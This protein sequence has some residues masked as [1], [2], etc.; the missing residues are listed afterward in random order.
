MNKEIKC[1]E[2]REIEKVEERLHD[3]DGVKDEHTHME[4]VE[5]N[6]G[7]LAECFVTRCKQ[8]DSL[9][10][11]RGEGVCPLEADHDQV[12]LVELCEVERATAVDGYTQS[13]GGYGNPGSAC[14]GAKPQRECPGVCV[15]ECGKMRAETRA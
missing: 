3:K 10:Q 9:L 2:T 6:G 8:L 12:G 4:V 5:F 14:G 15:D 1:I 7:E 13:L 11:E